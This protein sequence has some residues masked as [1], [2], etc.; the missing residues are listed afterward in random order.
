M[1]T[2]LAFLYVGVSGHRLYL[3]TRSHLPSRFKLK[4][5]TD[6]FEELLCC[7]GA[8]STAFGTMRSSVQVLSVLYYY[9]G[10]DGQDEAFCPDATSSPGDMA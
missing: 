10:G 5:A 1:L 8:Q 3:S 9:S 6:E 2:C 7:G 4:E